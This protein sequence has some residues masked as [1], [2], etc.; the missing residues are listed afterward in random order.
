MKDGT[1]VVLSEA[2]RDAYPSQDLNPHGLSG[3]VRLN[4]PP[5]SER[6]PY[7]VAW[8]NGTSNEY[9]HGEI[10]PAGKVAKGLPLPTPPEETT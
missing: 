5:V 9:K 1:E 4:S 10:E 8:S 7:R 6:W 2:G 3:V